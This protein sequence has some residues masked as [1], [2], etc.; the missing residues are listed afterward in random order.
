M[1]ETYKNFNL[2]FLNNCKKHNLKLMIFLPSHNSFCHLFDL[3]KSAII[4]VKSRPNWHFYRDRDRD[5]MS[6]PGIGRV[7]V[8]GSRS[9]PASDHLL[10]T[11]RSLDGH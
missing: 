2:M 11:R 5:K 4:P 1:K 9:I 7:P 6:N 8:P 10:A 3:K